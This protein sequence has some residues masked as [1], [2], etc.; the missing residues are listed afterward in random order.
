M[1]NYLNNNK[2]QRKI[3]SF[4]LSLAMVWTMIPGLFGAGIVYAEAGDKPDHAKTSNAN[5]IA[6]KED[7]TYQLELSVT[8]DADTKQEASNVN[9]LVVYDVSSSM[10]S[11]WAESDTGW[12]GTTSEYWRDGNYLSNNGNTIGDNTTVFN[13]YKRSGNTYTRIQPGEIYEGTVYRRNGNNY[14]V[15]NAGTGNNR[16]VTARRA[17]VSEKAV[18]GLVDDLFDYQNEDKTNINMGLITF[19]GTAHVTQPWT[20]NETDITNKISNTGTSKKLTY[21]SGTNWEGA[22]RAAQ[23]QI[24]SLDNDY[25][26]YVLFI[27][28]GSPSTEGNGGST[29]GPDTYPGHA[30][31]AYD[32]ARELNT[33]EETYLYGIYAF[34]DDYDYLDDLMY[35]AGT[36]ERRQ[37]RPQTDPADNYYNAG[38]TEA[39]NEAI[40]NIFG[41]IVQALGI[42]A[43]E[44]KDGTTH[45]VSASSGMIEL[46]EVDESSYQYWLSVPI[47]DGK[48]QRVKLNGDNAGETITYTV[49]DNGNGTCTVTWVDGGNKS[50]TVNGTKTNTQFKYEWTEANALYNQN[51]PEAHLNGS[52]V[53]WNLSAVGT[54]LDGVTY[55]VTFD[56]WP[57][58]T[59]LDYIADIEN[60]YYDQI[61]SEVKQY[62]DKDGKL[63][64][65]TT[66]TLSYKD[67]RTGETDSLDYTNPDPVESTAVEQ[68]AVAKEWTNDIDGQQSAPIDLEVTR[69]GTHKYDII[70]SED[71]QWKGNVYISIGIMRTDKTTGEMEVLEPGHDFTFVEPKNI[72]Y[73]WE[74]DIPT[75]R[76]M[77][78]DGTLTMLI[79]V[80]ENHQPGDA[81]VY[82]DPF[83][84][85]ADY[86]EGSTGA[87]SLTAT[88]YRRSQIALTKAVTGDA[89]ADAK[90]PFTLSVTNSRADTGTEGDTDSDKYVWFLVAD[91]NGTTVKSQEYITGG[92]TAEMSG[93][94]FTGFYYAESGASISAEIPAGYS[95]RFI[96]LP[97]DSSYTF[98][99][100]NLATGFK[101]VKAELTGG[102]DQDK[103]EEF[104]VD[105]KTA[106][107]KIAEWNADYLATFTNDYE[108]TDVTVTKAWDDSSNADG[109]RP[110]SLDLTLN[111]VPEGTS[112]PQPEITKNGN[113]WTYTWKELPKY[114]AAGETIN[115]TV[116]ETTIP[117]GYT[118]NTTTVNAGGTITNSHTPEMI[119]IPV[120][121]VWDDEDDNDGI[122][123]SSVK[124]D[125]KAGSEIVTG[126]TLTLDESNQWSGTFTDLPKYKDGTEIVYTVVEQTDN[127][128]TGEDGDGT[129]AISYAKDESGQF[130]VTNTH[131]PT[132]TNFDVTKV[133]VDANNR[134]G[135]R[136]ETVTVQL[137]ANNEPYGDPVVLTE[138]PTEAQKE[139]GYGA[140]YYQWKDL[141][142]KSD[143]QDITYSVREN[144]VDHYKP[145][146]TAYIPLR[147]VV[148]GA[149]QVDER[150][151]VVRA[152]SGHLLLAHLGLVCGLACGLVVR[153][154]GDATLRSSLVLGRL[155]ES[156]RKVRATQVLAVGLHVGSHVVEL[157]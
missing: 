43:V 31:A 117:A 139:Q 14:S 79:K 86:Y 80:D 92:A 90:F 24:N 77:L 52:S 9:I 118:C 68:L 37:Q 62:I 114:N 104:V 59:T 135:Y 8:G 110:T 91:K 107:G 30:L 84:N 146:Y 10:C 34:G 55:S 32:E 101:F 120:R 149:A 98:T 49:T 4:V 99:E 70:L 156:A 74:L 123:P 35:Y 36:G 142:V 115:Y 82:K 75:I 20:T 71:N 85:G 103:D 29:G 48:F 5:K 65:N 18:Y 22:L 47:V 153:R 2:W 145:T 112:V 53:D 23:T 132:L 119:S 15:F 61:P 38:N 76:P 87:A 94:S 144:S 143:G 157:V 60:G 131:T 42:S 124:V 129:Y 88:N 6:G 89:P 25:P 111:G 96:N 50:V 67:T 121:K 122:R 152:S 141:P 40:S 128:I 73:R 72:G 130:I 108:L 138:T 3:L 27:T 148:V 134:D 147:V 26:T 150:D 12:Y 56:V 54:L 113:N 46:L 133:W 155:G 126:K 151:T 11:Y 19:D 51:P 69:D 95:I 137:L 41:Q 106:T 78:I 28:D 102:S 83:G 100:G 116:T 154:D 44:I 16:R 97:T 57:S 7:G 33:R 39:L 58:Q 13:L 127:V 63:Q 81:K 140:W 109:C 105:G 136:P 17:D 64:T 1:K 21:A 125:V 93:G 66:A 45:E